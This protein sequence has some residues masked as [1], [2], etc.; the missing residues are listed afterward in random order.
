MKK[1]YYL[2]LIATQLLIGCKQKNPLNYSVDVIMN[3]EINS[4]DSTLNG[5]TDLKQI[6]SPI[7]KTNCDFYLMPNGKII[8]ANGKVNN[9]VEVKVTDDLLDKLL[10]FISKPKEDNLIKQMEKIRESV[11]I[12]N[13]FSNK[14][15]ENVSSL[16]EILNNG[17]YDKV[18]VFAPKSD[19]NKWNDLNVFKTI[20]SLQ[21][22]IS[23]EICNN[24]SSKIAV[25]FNPFGDGNQITLQP[26]SIDNFSSE[27]SNALM[28]IADVNKD[29]TERNNLI[30]ETYKKYFSPECYV[31]NTIT[32]DP[33]NPE[34]WDAGRSKDYLKHLAL[35]NSIG[36]IEIIKYEFAVNSKDKKLTGLKVH[37]MRNGSS[38]VK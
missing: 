16:S 35:M 12:T 30:E 18:F 37:E 13:L 33:Q 23:M 26:A 11:N 28:A 25:V 21:F 24:N 4:T 3:T 27:L 6:Y 1:V 38:Q 36:G 8:M 31:Q 7:T 29:R 20:D 34:F 9:F 10:K 19:N 32:D 2:I 17:K 15:T 5:T 14:R 22:Y